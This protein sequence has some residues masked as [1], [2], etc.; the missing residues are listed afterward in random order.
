[1]ITV[2]YTRT[3]SIYKKL[4]QDCYDINRDAR[5]YTGGNSIIA[6]P[7][8]RAWGQLS[9]MAKPRPDEK[10]LAIH[11]LIMVRLYGGI[12]E[13]PRNSKL[14]KTMKLPMPGETDQYGGWTLCINQIWWGHRAEKKTFLY[15]VGCKPKEIPDLPITFDLP[16]RGINDMAKPE[17]ERTPEKLAIWLIQLAETCNKNLK[18]GKLNGQAIQYM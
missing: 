5:S 6:H 10:S 17:R 16:I 7:P 12:L 8:C 13:H 4:G 14:W 18:M 15:I 11:S 9:H 2:L 1:M 3:N